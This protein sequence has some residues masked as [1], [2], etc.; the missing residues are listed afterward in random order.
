MK[1]KVFYV[2][3]MILAGFPTLVG[4]GGTP[5][6]EQKII[7]TPES[8]LPGSIPMKSTKPDGPVMSISNRPGKTDSRAFTDKLPEEHFRP[9][10]VDKTKAGF[11]KLTNM[12]EI[13]YELKKSKK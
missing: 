12:L 1:Y 8:V 5:S 6:S 3:S 4:C 13:H 10:S 2:M 7:N 9:Q 11:R